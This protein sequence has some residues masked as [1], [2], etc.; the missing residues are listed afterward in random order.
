MT[1]AQSA[2]AGVNFV[3]HAAGILGTAIG[4]SFEKFIVD[5]DACRTLRTALKKPTITAE[6]I[7]TQTIKD[8]GICGE[9]LSHPKT[10]EQCRTVFFQSE[11]RHPMDY[12]KWSDTGRR[13]IDDV[14]ADI[15]QKRL[16]E[17][18][19]P[20]IDPALELDLTR[21][22]AQRKQAEDGSG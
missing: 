13:R 16:L 19:K 5:E 9:Y 18:V 14:S 11:L 12:Q 17:Y 22:V 4:M 7:D 2:Q 21:F 6:T 20:D 8:V 15:V 1:L 3:L 10:L